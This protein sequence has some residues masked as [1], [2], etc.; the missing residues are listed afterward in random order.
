MKTRDSE[1]AIQKARRQVDEGQCG[2]TEVQKLMAVGGKTAEDESRSS[3]EDAADSQ[4]I[5]GSYSGMQTSHVFVQIFK[6]WVSC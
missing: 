3:V 5:S 4:R 6:A 1:E 2:V